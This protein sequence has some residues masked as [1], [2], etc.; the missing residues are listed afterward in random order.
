MLKCI[1]AQESDPARTTSVPRV[2]RPQQ[3]ATEA[4]RRARP[5]SEDPTEN[6]DTM[7]SYSTDDSVLPTTPI[8][9]QTV[10]ATS[11]HVDAEPTAPSAKDHAAQAA[12]TA[13][14]AAATAKDTAKETAGQAKDQAQRVGA[15]AAGAAQSV[16]STAKEQASTVAADAVGQARELYGQ[17]TT[18]LSEQA[19]KQQKSAAAT[20]HTF[21]DDLA[22]MQGEQSGLAAELVQTVSKSAGRVADWLE[23]REPAEVLDEVRQFAARRPGLFIG[24]AAISG[25]VAARAVKA[26]VAEAK[27]ADAAA[28][29]AP[30]TDS[31]STGTPSYGDV[32]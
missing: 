10:S 1:H 11:V 19:G 15:A 4:C 2:L 7:S 16:G 23:T 5:P 32:R 25:V 14:D 6:E 31:T 27:P 28:A 30:A 29:P 8:F 3:G 13:K 17:A 20:L 9:D 24:I 21:R 12:D 22:N 26:L 18:Q